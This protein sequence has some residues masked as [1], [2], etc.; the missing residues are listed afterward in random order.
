MPSLGQHTRYQVERVID[1][2]NQLLVLIK[3]SGGLRRA[4]AD[5]VAPLIAALQALRVDAV[6]END[7]KKLQEGEITLS[8]VTTGRMD[9]FP[10]DATKYVGSVRDALLA[11]LAS[12]DFKPDDVDDQIYRYFLEEVQH[13]RRG[14]SPLGVDAIAEAADIKRDDCRRCLAH[15]TDEN[16]LTR[17]YK[18]GRFVVAHERRLER[19]IAQIQEQIAA[20]ERNREEATVA[21]L[22]TRHLPWKPTPWAFISSVQRG[23]EAYRD[24]AREACLRARVLPVGM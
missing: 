5:Q 13:Q 9:L 2:C 14:T 19:R 11:I 12:Y 4:D 1:A 23:L 17:D 7:N 20:K 22:P 8:A 21:S 24:A 16:L 15:A 18:N 3:K 6:E 10:D